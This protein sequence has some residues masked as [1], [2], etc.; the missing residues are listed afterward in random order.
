M[1]YGARR[2][3]VGEVARGVAQSGRA[4]LGRV[5]GLARGGPYGAA[6]MEFLRPNTAHAPTTDRRAPT[7]YDRGRIRWRR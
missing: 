2:T 7:Q 3:I 1:V 5:V 6:A 4:G